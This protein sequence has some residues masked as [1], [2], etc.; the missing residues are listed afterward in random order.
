MSLF[1]YQQKMVDF[2]RE[3]KKVGLFVDMGMG[4]TLTALTAVNDLLDHD[5]RVFP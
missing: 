3:K 4:K 1:N 5:D 2:I